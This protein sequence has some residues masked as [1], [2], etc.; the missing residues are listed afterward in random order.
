MGLLLTSGF[1]LYLIIIHLSVYVDPLPVS[2]TAILIK[3]LQL[4]MA[5]FIRDRRLRRQRNV[6]GKL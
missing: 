5:T 1:L 2:L 6:R 3:T 4:F